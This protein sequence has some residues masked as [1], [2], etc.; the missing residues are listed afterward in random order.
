MELSFVYKCGGSEVV[1]LETLQAAAGSLYDN[2]PF[3]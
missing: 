3:P 2:A 1:P